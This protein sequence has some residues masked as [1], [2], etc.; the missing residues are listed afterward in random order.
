MRYLQADKVFNGRSLLEGSTVL[1]I[2]DKGELIEISD[3]VLVPSDKIEKLE[4]V[5]T[6]GFVNTHCHTELS[7]LKNKI[8]QKTGLPG[9]GKQIIF[10]RATA[11]REEIKEKLLAADHAMWNNGIVA[12]GDICNTADSF[13]MKTN[14]KIVYH[15]F[16]EL[17]GLHPEKAALSYEAGMLLYDQL[18]KHGLRGSLTPHAPYSTSFKLIQKIAEFNIENNFPASIHNQESEEETKFFYG[19]KNGF[20]ELYELLQMDL[21]WFKAPMKSSLEYF[22]PSLC[23]QQTILVHN[24]FTSKEDI[25]TASSKNIFWCFCPSANIYIED[26]LPDFNLFKSEKDKVCL[27]TDSLASNTE[28]SIINEANYLLKSG[29]FTLEEVLRSATSIPAKALNLSNIFGTFI[30]G[31]NTGLNLLELNNNNINFIKNLS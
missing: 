4:G 31:K 21:S 24:T 27:G 25:A 11:N 30:N 16:I 26:C 7:H 17:L 5:I 13:E 1:I 15:S 6:P 19:E 23:D 22:I 14:S 12:V 8:P 10:Q 28:L 18:K 20:Q 9:F 29:M 3:D 2:G